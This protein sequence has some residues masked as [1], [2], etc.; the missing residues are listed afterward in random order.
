ML[1]KSV[2]IFP[3]IHND[4]VFRQQLDKSISTANNLIDKYNLHG[5]KCI[6]YVGR[7]A[8]E[9]GLD[10]LVTAFSNVHHHFPE[11]LLIMIGE[12]N[13]RKY[14]TALCSKL[15][16]SN[17]VLLPGRTEGIKLYGWFNIAPLLVLASQY[18]P[19]GAVVNE[20]LLS[21]ADVL[22]STHAGAWWMIESGK[23]GEVFDPYDVEK[24]SSQLTDQL[25][26]MKPMEKIS[27]IRPSK[28]LTHFDDYTGKLHEK[29]L[30]DLATYQKN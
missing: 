8:V 29:L 15:S 4:Q 11:S 19:F 26:K 3:V 28:M 20:L 6:F 22:C 9:K 16:I 2:V 5:K 17:K 30:K 1:Q 13:Q 12:G 23:N 18:E 10:R 14:L 24:L 25:K 21:G 7:L 27:I